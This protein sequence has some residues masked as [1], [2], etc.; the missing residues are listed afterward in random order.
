MAVVI[1]SAIMFVAMIIGYRS[2]QHKA[3]NKPQSN[4]ESPATTDSKSP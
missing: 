1:V 3:P 4:T 2:P